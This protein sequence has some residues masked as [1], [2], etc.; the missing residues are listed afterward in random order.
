MPIASWMELTITTCAS[1]LTQASFPLELDFLW[2]DGMAANSVGGGSIPWWVF[3]CCTHPEQLDWGIHFKPQLSIAGSGTLTVAW[4]RLPL[5]VR[6]QHCMLFDIWRCVGEKL[7]EKLPPYIS[8]R[9]IR[10]EVLWPRL[11]FAM[12]V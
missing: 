8:C 5:D 10:I 7:R 3:R 1:S 2:P 11:L 6:L 12:W 9:K 4:P